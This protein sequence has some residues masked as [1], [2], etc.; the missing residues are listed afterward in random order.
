MGDW[1]GWVK[2]TISLGLGCESYRGFA[3]SFVLGTAACLGPTVNFGADFAFL[4]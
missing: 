4:P 2:A 3:D 1:L